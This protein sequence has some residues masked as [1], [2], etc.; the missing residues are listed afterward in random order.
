MNDITLGYI[1]VGLF[2]CGCCL[3]ALMAFGILTALLVAFLAGSAFV[4]S[5]DALYHLALANGI[6]PGLAWLWPL[7][8]DAVMIAASLAVLRNSLIAERTWYQ[9]GLVGAF[10]LLSVTFNTVHAPGSWL[11]RGIFALPPLVVF[12]AFELLV[13]QIKSAVRRGAVMQSIHDLAD[14]VSLAKNDLAEVNR[15]T[16]DM[17]AKRDTLRAEIE[18]LRREKRAA[19]CPNDT[20]LDLANETRQAQKD[21]RQNKIVGL[22]TGQAGLTYQELADKTGASLATVKRDVAE[23][24]EAGKLRRNGHGLEVAGSFDTMQEPLPVAAGVN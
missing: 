17:T 18:T 11:A 5:Y 10:T 3:W 22:V 24:T 9:W 7:T 23:L 14:Q 19:N 2:F 20:V 12:L 21:A 4:L 16:H 8:L 13:S 6:T 1:A 15:M